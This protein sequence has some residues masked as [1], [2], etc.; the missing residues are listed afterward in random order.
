MSTPKRKRTVLDDVQKRSILKYV[1]D[2]PKATQQQVAD[3]FS[4]YWDIPVKRRTVGDIISRKDTFDSDNEGSPARKRHRSA[5]HTDMEKCLYIWFTNARSKNVPVMDDLLREKA[6]QFGSETGVT[7]FS[8]SNGW[9]QRFKSRHSISS[10]IIC[11]ESA[12]I[13][14]TLIDNG[15]QE[16][17]RKM[18]N[19]DPKNIF[20]V[21]ETGLFF[22]MLPDRSLTTTEFTKGTKKAKDRIT[23]TLC[24]NADGS[25]KLKPLVIGKSLKPRCF[26]NFHVEL[27]VDYT[28]NK[29]SWM[30]SVIFADFLKTVNRKMKRE[31]R[32]ILLIM[33]NAP[34]HAIPDL[35]NIEVHFL[36]PTTTSHL[37]PLDAGIIQ[38]FKGHYR[39]SQLKHL[40]QC[41]DND[42]PP[43]IS[44]KQ[45]IRFIKL[46]WDDV[47][48]RTIVNCWKH[49]GLIERENDEVVDR[50]INVFTRNSDN[51]LMSRVY[52]DLDIDPDMRL[53]ISEFVEID[54]NAEIAED[55][56]DDMI[57][58]AIQPQTSDTDSVTSV[59][60]D[61]DSEEVQPPCKTVIDCLSTA[62]K[63]FEMESSTTEADI[64]KLIS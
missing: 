1:E 34:S 40:V 10:H 8:Y 41:I 28:A 53:T 24:C 12:G 7:D 27:Y 6:K 42:E 58:S 5:H 44:L 63:F 15:R 9:L 55:V 4:I 36:P 50:N 23:V 3:H 52:E 38:C 46:A 18:K 51:M 54:R 60:E 11:G 25:E 2:N 21:D 45:A 19:F 49:T 16:A 39:R 32:K 61:S 57:L 22:R 48:E 13:D 37:Q 62:I 31:R 26:K 14:K 17:I 47:T 29:K 35:S 43:A 30:N 20:N 33:D 59:D 64:S 56:T